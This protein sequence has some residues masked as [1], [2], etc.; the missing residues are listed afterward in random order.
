MTPP[1]AGAAQAARLGVVWPAGS[2]AAAC[3][4]A[5]VVAL[6]VVESVAAPRRPRVPHAWRWSRP[7]GP[8]VATAGCTSASGVH[9]ERRNGQPYAA[10]GT[11]GLAWRMPGG[12]CGG[13]AGCGRYRLVGRR[14]WSHVV[15]RIG[16]LHAAAG[17]QAPRAAV[18]A[19]WP[20]RP[21]LGARRRRWAHP[22]WWNR[23]PRPVGRAA[24]C[25]G[26]GRVLPVHRGRCRGSG[27]GCRTRRSRRIGPNSRPA[28]LPVRRPG[29]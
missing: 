5:S 23:W 27:C 8:G 21:P 18:V 1:P 3:G 7:T 6:G 20:V 16:W 19:D 24:P 22:A 11:A 4:P 26:P 12:G 25:S 15:W 2:G 10:A 17:P 14:G 9:P 13:L 28:T 29:C